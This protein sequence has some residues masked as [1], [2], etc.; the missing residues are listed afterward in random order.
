MNNLT[1][2][3]IPDPNQYEEF[4]KSMERFQEM[5]KRLSENCLASLSPALTQIAREISQ[6]SL[7]IMN[8]SFYV[9]M[10]ELTNSIP[11][12]EAVK[13]SQTA[14]Q[15]ISQNL[16]EN[17]NSIRNNIYYGD[18]INQIIHSS[19]DTN[20]VGTNSDDEIKEIEF[21]DEQLT[22]I[23]NLNININ[24]YSDN[25]KSTENKKIFTIPNL[26]GFISI[27]ISIIALLYSIT[28]SEETTQQN[29]TAIEIEAK[30]NE[31]LDSI[32][33]QLSESTSDE[34]DAQYSLANSQ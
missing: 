12:S 8:N 18:F 26:L 4:R 34:V 22:H 13:A 2:N 30:T 7:E 25:E 15:L 16:A 9:A 11:T 6:S 27:L 29:E 31:L 19:N 23:E 5:S 17:L 24:V 28:S 21:T 32:Y 33:K 1:F 10:K 20:A 14:L 3:N